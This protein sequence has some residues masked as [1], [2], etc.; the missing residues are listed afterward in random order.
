MLY[1]SILGF[2]GQ[3][4]HKYCM[5][6]VYQRGGHTMGDTLIAMSLF[7]SLNQPV[8]ITTSSASLYPMWKD[9]LNIDDRITIDIDDYCD[10]YFDPPHPRFLE[11]FKIYNRY[12][13]LN[14]FKVAST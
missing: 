8:H 11:S 14:K 13:E 10:L 7:Y 2:F 6:R 4:A 12:I 1:Y 3:P 5:I 9:V